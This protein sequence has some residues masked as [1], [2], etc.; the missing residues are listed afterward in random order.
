MA[1]RIQIRNDISTIW[2]L[3]NPILAN[4]ELGLE[5]D[6]KNIKM[7]DGKTA[8]NDLEYGLSGESAYQT[9]LRNGFVGTE[10]EWLESL[11]SIPTY[12]WI[13]FAD[14]NNGTGITD[15]PTDKMYMG[16][17]YNQAVKTESNDP[18]D[19]KWTLFRGSDGIKG[20][21]GTTYYTWIK[22]ADDKMGSNMSDEPEGK[23]YMGIT[24][25]KLTPQESNDPLEYKWTLYK[26]TD[27]I[28]GDNGENGNDGKSAYDIAIENGFI[29]TEQEWLDSLR[30]TDGVKGDKG[31]VGATFS[32]TDGVLTINT[33]D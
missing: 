13:K 1:S 12:T 29:G 15:D 24:Y 3:E 32:F 14:D 30:G 22:F 26:G 23:G 28:N 31:E 16:V 19:Y 8:W 25:N 33:N 2:A 4:G 7:G 21:D 9:A 27:G 11:K 5:T 18:V 6:T 17:A 20:E 10:Q